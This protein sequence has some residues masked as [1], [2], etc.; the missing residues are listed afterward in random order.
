MGEGNLCWAGHFHLMSPDEQNITLNNYFNHKM[1]KTDLNMI[2][3]SLYSEIPILQTKIKLS[4]ANTFFFFF[5]SSFNNM[6]FLKTYFLCTIFA[7]T[8]I[9]LKYTVWFCLNGKRI[10]GRLVPRIMQPWL[11]C[12]QLVL[13]LHSK[14]I[15]D[16]KESDIPSQI[17]NP[18]DQTAN[19]LNMT[20]ATDHLQEESWHLVLQSFVDHILEGE[21][22]FYFFIIMIK[23]NH[24]LNF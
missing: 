9:S 6:W 5:L 18:T 14:T 17:G 10:Q 19:W 11:K 1:L 8:N 22:R 3:K 23:T 15:I 2:M 21:L 13:P 20:R 7:Y 16:S 4:R 12:I 24:K